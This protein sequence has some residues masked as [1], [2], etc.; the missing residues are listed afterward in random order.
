MKLQ[1][2][3]RILG[4]QKHLFVY[5]LLHFATLWYK[6]KHVWLHSRSAEYDV[7]ELCDLYAGNALWGA[8][9]GVRISRCV[10]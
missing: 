9:W 7:T 8:L 4:L 1:N 3:Y 5:D 10:S 2:A 6:M